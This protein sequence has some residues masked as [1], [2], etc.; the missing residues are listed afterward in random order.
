MCTDMILFRKI[1]NAPMYDT[2]Q[3]RNQ[4]LR[5]RSSLSLSLSRAGDLRGQNRVVSGAQRLGRPDE[6]E[7][8]RDTDDSD[9]S[10]DSD[11]GADPGKHF[12]VT[13]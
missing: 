10:D 7:Q 11:G 8:R 2:V 3:K 4:P 13:V 9:D 6:S 5:P 12:R 1:L